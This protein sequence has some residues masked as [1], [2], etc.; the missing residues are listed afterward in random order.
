M[1]R[2]PKPALCF[3]CDSR[4]QWP[5]KFASPVRREFSDGGTLVVG[6]KEGD[7]SCSLDGGATILPVRVE[8]K[9]LGDLFGCVGHGRERFERELERLMAYP[10]RALVIEATMD[11]VLRGYERSQISGRAAL[12]SLAG[13]VIRFQIHPH[14]AENHRRAG[15]WIQRLLEEAAV[16]HLRQQ[17]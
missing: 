16:N 7:Y 5:I 15:G 9:S 17:R 13:W 1:P 8:R 14:F 3:L 2:A 12:T 4:E 10:Y 6:L 11:D